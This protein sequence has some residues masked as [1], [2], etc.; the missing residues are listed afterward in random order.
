[1]CIRDRPAI[2]SLLEPLFDGFLGHAAA[3]LISFLIAYAVIT[4]LHVIFGEQAPKMV[5]IARAE[6]LLLGISRPLEVF[7]RLFHP[8]I[9]LTNAPARFFVARVLRIEPEAD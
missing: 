1:M 6:T 8:L 2:A 7:R 5:G 9:L 3:L 4:L